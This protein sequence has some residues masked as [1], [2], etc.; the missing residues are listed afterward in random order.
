MKMESKKNYRHSS[1]IILKRRRVILF[2]RSIR[3]KVKEKNR[4]IVGVKP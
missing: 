2:R 1:K 3:K 4:G